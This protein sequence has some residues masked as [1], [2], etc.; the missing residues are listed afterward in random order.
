[1]A[2]ITST[3]PETEDAP[4]SVEEYIARFVDG[5]E[6]PT[7]EYIDGELFPKSMGTKKH[8][9]TQQNIQYYIR[10]KYGD[11]FDPLPELTARLRT[12]K[13][14]VPDIAVED[15]AHPMQGRYPGA[16][17]PVFLCVEIM[18]PPDRIGKVFGKCEEYHKWG[19]GRCWV[20]DPERR[21]PGNTL[22]KTLSP[23]ALRLR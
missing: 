16:K 14:Y 10:Q 12:K 2:A 21:W 18:S 3:M 20:L 7:C 6:K 17:D 9:K 11:A 8:S 23:A 13:F 19:V 1:M 5:S 22:P 15:L 4:V